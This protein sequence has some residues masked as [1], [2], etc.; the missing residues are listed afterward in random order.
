MTDDAL[1]AA[2]SSVDQ[3]FIVVNSR[4][5]ALAL[6][7][8]A[9]E[10]RLDGAVHLTTRQYA[11]HR[12]EILSRIKEALKAGRRCRLI[13]T[14]LIEAGIDLDFEAG[15]RA[16]AGLESIV[17]AAGRV[18]RE[19]KRARE[20]SVLTVFIP[21]DDPPQPEIARRA[22]A[23]ERL[24]EALWADLAAPAALARY[25]EEVYW[26]E[27]DGL[28]VIVVE[29]GGR[30]VNRSVLKDC[31]KLSGRETDFAFR[32]VGENFRLIES[33][34]VPV[35][36]ARDEP[37]R[38]ALDRL[39]WE[40]VSAGSVARA[41]QPYTVQVPPRARHRLVACEHVQ[42]REPG[43][44]GEQFAVLEADSLYRE[45]EGLLWEDEIYLAIEE[46]IF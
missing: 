44:F 22:A 2:L 26:Q 15:W 4:K 10:A 24:P 5:H 18:N 12:R 9:K 41:L 19:G 32:T 17:Q 20:D 30:K 6:Y 28:D 25:F 34:M 21:A 14:S 11:A 23:M 31:F 43:R 36:V 29:E 45:E 16:M 33:G 39:R 1:V 40:N 38:R 42:F 7:R 27:G 8:R 46:T 3:G 35:I 13:A 37:A